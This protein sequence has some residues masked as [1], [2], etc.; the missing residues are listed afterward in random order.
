MPAAGSL[1]PPIK[2]GGETGGKTATNRKSKHDLDLSQIQQELAGQHK[3]DEYEVKQIVGAIR[4]DDGLVYYAVVWEKHEPAGGTWERADKFEAPTVQKDQKLLVQWDILGED[5]NGRT[6]RKRKHSRK[7][8]CFWAEASGEFSDTQQA[9]FVT[10]K[11]QA[12]ATHTVENDLHKARIQVTTDGTLADEHWLDLYTL[13]AKRVPS[14]T[15]S[16]SESEA[17]LDSL[18][19]ADEFH[20]KSWILREYVN[21]E[22]IYKDTD[23]ALIVVKKTK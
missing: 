23:L 16:V 8:H 15:Q 9:H 18:R 19:F 12:L 22:F 21:A 4:H 11:Q 3:V 13:A 6:L 7:A 17:G 20:V 2:V 10:Y 5:S 14:D 1:P